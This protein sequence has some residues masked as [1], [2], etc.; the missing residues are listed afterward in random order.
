MALR[1]RI[2]LTIAV[3]ALALTALVASSAV[4]GPAARFAV[5]SSALEQAERIAR[6]HWGT[7]AC[8]GSV[9]LRWVRQDADINALSTWTTASPDPYADPSDNRDCSIALNPAAHF[10]WPKLCTVIVH[11]YGHLTGHDHDRRP[12]RLMSEVYTTP[13]EQCAAPTARRAVA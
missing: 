8:G 7:D 4:A 12:G 5:G 13:L 9:A 10:D 6:D 11:E 1:T 3:A 2:T